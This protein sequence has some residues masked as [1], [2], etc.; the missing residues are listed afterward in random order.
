M[1]DYNN[2]ITE[3]VVTKAFDW[4]VYS[5]FDWTFFIHKASFRLSQKIDLGAKILAKIGKN[6]P[7][8]ES[9]YI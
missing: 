4:N 5:S 3:V 2:S 1:D 8:R 7:P 9:W 6:L